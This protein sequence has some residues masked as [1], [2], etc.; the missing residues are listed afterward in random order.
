MDANLTN[1]IIEL[2]I[3]IPSILRRK[4]HREFFKT[5]L[6]QMGED[7]TPQHLMI[8]KTLLESG[9]LHVS[10]IGDE[11]VISRSQMTHLTDKLISLSMIERQP[12]SRDR[13]KINIAL[14]SK[15]EETIEK[16]TQLISNNIKTK[17]SLI[18]EEE[19]KILATSLRNIVNIFAKIH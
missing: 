4:A 15:G 7:I 8:M 5:A 13:R 6:K 12:D 18:P 3:S 11:L 10:E 1:E 19:L 14:T 2:L 17:L 9:P 16:V